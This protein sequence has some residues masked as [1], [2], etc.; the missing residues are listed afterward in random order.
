VTLIQASVRNSGTCSPDVKGKA[1]ADRI[2][3]SENTN[4]GHRGGVVRSRDE[5]LVMGLDRRNDVV[6]LCRD[7]NL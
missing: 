7:G 6:W 3:K 1:Q 5:D 4:A 2:C